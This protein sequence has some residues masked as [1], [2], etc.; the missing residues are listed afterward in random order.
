MGHSKNS[1]KRSVYTGLP[2]IQE[3]SQ[4]EFTPKGTRKRKTFPVK[5]GRNNKD[6][7]ENK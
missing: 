6:Q 1:A 3:K 5:E 7:K 2:K 4:S